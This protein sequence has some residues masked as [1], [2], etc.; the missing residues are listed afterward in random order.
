MGRPQTLGRPSPGEVLDDDVLPRCADRATRLSDP[1][2]G[3]EEQ[4]RC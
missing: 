2:A 3:R 4:L 1:A